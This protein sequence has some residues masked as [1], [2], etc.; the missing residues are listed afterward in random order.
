LGGCDNHHHKRISV[1]GKEYGEFVDKQAN[2]QDASE[3]EWLKALKLQYRE[4]ECVGSK[5]VSSY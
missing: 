5:K 3:R 4:E 2:W 1:H